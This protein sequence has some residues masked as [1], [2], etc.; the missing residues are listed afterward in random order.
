MAP[1][2][3]QE[4]EQTGLGPSPLPALAGVKWGLLPT[5]P[6]APTWP[7]RWRGRMKGSASGC[8]PPPPLAQVIGGLLPPDLLAFDP[9]PPPGPPG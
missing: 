8:S 4:D 7:P 9:P 6:L 1:A 3:A 5:H 2:L